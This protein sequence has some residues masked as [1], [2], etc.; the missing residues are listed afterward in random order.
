MVEQLTEIDVDR[1]RE[2]LAEIEERVAGAAVTAGRDRSQ[3]EIVAATKY[4][5]PGALGAL[6]EAGVK[7]V[8]ENRQQDLVAKQE[9]WGD[10]FTWDFIGDLQSRKVPSLVGRVRLIHS[11]ASES[12]LAKFERDDARDQRILVQVNISGEESKGGIAPSDLGSFIERAACDVVGLMTMPPLASVPEDNRRYF[13]AL[14]DLADLHGLS[15]L[16]MGTSQ[17]FEIAVEEGATMVRI[18]A[19]LCR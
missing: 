4:V 16:S 8:G 1:V 11:V 12:A 15:E 18:G 10:L 5:S 17:D 9:L 19:V 6:A 7:C 14:R 3:I 2:N 13:A